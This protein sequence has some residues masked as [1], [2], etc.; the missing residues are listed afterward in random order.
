MSETLGSR[1]SSLRQQ[2]QHG[3]QEGAELGSLLL[4][5]LIL[6]QQDL[7]QTPRLQLG[8]ASQLPCQEYNGEYKKDSL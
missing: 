2:L 8:D 6:I 7:Q 4:G 1:G 5:P 3:E